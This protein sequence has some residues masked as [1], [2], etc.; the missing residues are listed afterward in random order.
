MK[1]SIIIPTYKRPDKLIRAVQSV[2]AQ[3]IKSF[4][5]I[6]AND[7]PG[8]SYAAFET[9]CIGLTDDQKDQIVY[10]QNLQNSGSNFSKNAALG[11]VSKSTDYV[12]FLDD[13]DWLSSNALVDI[14]G[15]LK[16]NM[17]AW[18]VTNRVLKDGKSLT[19][20]PKEKIHYFWDYLIT[21]RVKGDATHIIKRAYATRYSFS[22]N[23]K[24]TEEWFYFIQLPVDAIYKP[25][26]TTESEGYDQD[27][28]TTNLQMIYADNT[29]LLMREARGFKMHI[30]LIIRYVYG[31][32]KKQKSTGNNAQG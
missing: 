3:K 16:R 17:V 5:I 4:E 23:A 1:Y 6:I 29:K 24:N 20:S 19:F 28:I 27:G 21:K 15:Y 8:Y 7:S 30:Y 31:M 22:K 26:N 14:D 18:L 2:F 10:I 25:Y 9:Y 13:D 11:Q 12:M 32:L